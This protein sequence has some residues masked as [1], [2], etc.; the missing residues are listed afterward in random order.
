MACGWA[1]SFGPSSLGGWCAGSVLR[2][3]PA[4]T[5][6]FD[7]RQSAPSPSGRSG[8][9][10]L[11]A[12]H[13]RRRQGGHGAPIKTPT[14]ALQ[15]VRLCKTHMSVVRIPTVP[16][17]H[18]DWRSKPRMEEVIRPREGGGIFPPNPGALWFY[19][20]EYT[21]ILPTED[22]IIMLLPGLRR[23][24]SLYRAQRWALCWSAGH[25]SRSDTWLTGLQHGGNG[26]GTELWSLAWV[27]VF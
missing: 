2:E 9:R 12:R 4:G 11:G 19:I 17:Q 5:P 3:L 7:S 23:R 8:G 13:I 6:V 16:S 18:H 27:F 14:V 10:A 1:G 25:H 21:C 24:V 26:L 20:T 15:H 22:S